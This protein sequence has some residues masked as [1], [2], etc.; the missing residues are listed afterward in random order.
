MRGGAA[1]SAGSALRRRSRWHRHGRPGTAAESEWRCSL[2]W[3]PPFSVVLT[4]PV[5]NPLRH[6]RADNGLRLVDGVL[7]CCLVDFVRIRNVVV[8]VPADLFE[9]RDQALEL[10]CRLCLWFTVGFH[11]WIAFGTYKKT[12]RLSRCYPP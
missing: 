2:S 11:W 8:E 5:D 1:V 12:A 7:E 4:N 9:A 3:L 6:A 10:R